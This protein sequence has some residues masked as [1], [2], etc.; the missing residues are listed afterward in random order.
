MRLVK[1]LKTI[2]AGVL[3]AA[4]GAAGAAA[5]VANVRIA[6][7]P[8][9]TYLPLV[10]MQHDKL[11]EKNAKS[12]GL[13]D[14]S[15]TWHKFAGGNVMNDA[16]LSGNL[17]FAATGMP[18][19]LI[20]WDK[21]K[22]IL[23][24]KGLCSYG[25]TPL[26]LVTRNPN[27]RTIRDFTESD[28]IAV[29]AVRS[30]VQAIVLQMASEKEW[31]RGNHGKLDGLTVSRAHPDAMTA[32]L[33]AG[34]EITAHFGAPPYQY[35]AL[36]NPG[37]H[38]VLNTYDI[39]GG[40]ASN[41]IFYTTAEFHRKNPKL[42]GAIKAAMSEAVGSIKADPRGAAEK[43]LAATGEKSSVD[44]ILS[45]IQAPGVTYTLAPE[46]SFAYASFMH[47]I[48]SIKREAESWKDL[49]FPEAHDLPGS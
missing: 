15:V 28:R 32:L 40:P 18:S 37:I 44:D 2:A 26:Y 29:P 14:V 30:S 39:F 13:G 34:T 49:F 16:L 24:V 11:I 45:Q 1:A 38:R 20:L 23:D 3:L 17:D 5:E 31:G 21:A 9:L 12:S 10:M 36:R 22:G 4:V 46:N 33:S 19:F 48:G 42:M 27:V 7:Q 35:I 41:G 43:Y 8:G 25:S 47:R 6:Q